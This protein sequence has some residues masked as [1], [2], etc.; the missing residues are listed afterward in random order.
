[1]AEV[2]ASGCENNARAV[3]DTV[4]SDSIKAGSIVNSKQV[5]QPEPQTTTHMVPIPSEAHQVQ[6]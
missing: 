6:L 2:L 5:Y 4:L 1:M 3:G